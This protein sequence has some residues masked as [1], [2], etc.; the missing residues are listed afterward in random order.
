MTDDPTSLSSARARARGSSQS[1]GAATDPEAVRAYIR[2]TAGRRAESLSTALRV[3]PG[4]R[5]STHEGSR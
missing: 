4:R 5:G 3:R 1:H 2:A